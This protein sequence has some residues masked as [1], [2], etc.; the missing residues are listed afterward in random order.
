MTGMIV[1]HRGSDGFVCVF[2]CLS[3]CVVLYVCLYG[4]V[5]TCVCVFPCPRGN[6]RPGV[7]T[8]HL[9]YQSYGA[10]YI[11]HPCAG[12]WGSETSDIVSD[13]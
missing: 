11:F 3:S 4:C 13:I 7:V 2:E 9:I 8:D 1:I 5:H 10:P 6:S 12:P